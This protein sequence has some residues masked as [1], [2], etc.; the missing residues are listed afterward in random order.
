DA[1]ARGCGFV[2]TQGTLAGA[3]Q[4]T[5]PVRITRIDG[6]ENFSGRLNESGVGRAG[7][8]P[9]GGSRRHQLQAGRHAFVLRAMVEQFDMP[10][11]DK[12]LIRHHRDSAIG[13]RADNTLAIDIEPGHG[14]WIGGRLLDVPIDQDSVRDGSWWE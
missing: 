13:A 7:L 2:T 4:R 12:R 6:L 9:T 11:A 14:Y 5:F 10:S 1:V 8:A 3:G